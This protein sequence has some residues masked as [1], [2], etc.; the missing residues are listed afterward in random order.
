[1]HV[2]TVEFDIA[3]EHWASFMPAML[4]NAAMSLA[5]EP[6][7]RQFDVC[8]GAP[9]E[10][11]VFLYELYDTAHDFDLHLKAEHFLRFNAQTQAWV[12]RKQVKVYSRA[13]PETAQGAS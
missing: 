4:A 9:G 3:P 13:W 2:V 5:V 7:C 1:M 11:R 12:S 10:H 8:E 6:G